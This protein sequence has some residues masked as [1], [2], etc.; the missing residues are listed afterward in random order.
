MSPLSVCKKQPLLK[1]PKM[2]KSDDK[3]VV[4]WQER[5][6]WWYFDAYFCFHPHGKFAFPVSKNEFLIVS[7]PFTCSIIIFNILPFWATH[8]V[9]VPAQ[10]WSWPWQMNLDFRVLQ[11]YSQLPSSF[12]LDKRTWTS[13]D[14]IIPNTTL[15]DKVP[16]TSYIHRTLAK[17]V[18]L[19]WTLVELEAG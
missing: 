3:F 18:K 2:S 6:F 4:S 1:V 13:G 19:I 15:S 10:Q 16:C 17:Y 14:I 7:S 12:D 5:M 8:P 11:L 9:K